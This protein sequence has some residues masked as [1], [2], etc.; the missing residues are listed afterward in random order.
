MYVPE[1]FRQPDQEQI[2]S[3]IQGSPLGI[4]VTAD[5]TGINANHLPFE[6][7][8][9][10]GEFGS[11]LCHVARSNTAWQGAD[12]L[13]TESLVIF[14]GPAAYISPTLYASKKETHKVVPTYNYVAVH[15]YG[16]IVVHDD[17]RWLRGLVG[18]LTQRFET[19]RDDPWK[20][21][22][23][24]R[25]YIDEQLSRIVGLEIQISRLEG[26]W[27]MSQNR[28]VADQEG[29]IAGLGVSVADTERAVAA[30]MRRRLSET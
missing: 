1:H 9:S 14:Q 6:L 24:P 22:D 2:Y 13:P 11:V 7:D 4:L 20:M 5:A 25:D 8:R 15:A 28:S 16:R 3:A 27:K 23:A 21:G 29:V 17:P 26:K 12:S 30:V 10:Q 18:R 19:Q